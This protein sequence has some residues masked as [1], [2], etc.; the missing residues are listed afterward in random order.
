MITVTAFTSCS[1]RLLTCS[2]DMAAGPRH[3][4]PA[5]ERRRRCGA[6]AERRGGEGREG[7][8]RARGAG[9]RARRLRARAAG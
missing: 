3:R 8:G 6:A 7:E 4:V 9:A 1:H 5:A 2:A